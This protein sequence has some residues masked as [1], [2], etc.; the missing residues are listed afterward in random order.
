MNHV[1][2]GAGRYVARPGMSAVSDRLGRPLRNLRLSVTD[3][4]N[5]RCQYCMPEADYVWLPKA[6][7]L[8]FEEIAELIGTSV[9]TAFRRF[10]SGLESL[11]AHP[12]LRPSAAAAV[13]HDPIRSREN[14]S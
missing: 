6:D 14:R 13:A 2:I 12:Q 4:C 5:L 8:T 7:V 3:R 10:R 1:V 11:R 9:P